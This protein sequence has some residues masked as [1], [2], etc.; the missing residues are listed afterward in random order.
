MI[1]I[2]PSYIL[3]LISVSF[4]ATEMFNVPVWKPTSANFFCGMEC[5]KRPG[6]N[7]WQNQL[8]VSKQSI[9]QV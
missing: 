7:F 8:E 5:F 9:L 4:L 3:Q 6:V 2:T 1:T